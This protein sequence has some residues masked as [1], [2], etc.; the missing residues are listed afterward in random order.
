MQYYNRGILK[1][2]K[3]RPQRTRFLRKDH[4]KR[5]FQLI[6]DKKF[7]ISEFRRTVIALKSFDFS[8]LTKNQIGSKPT[9]QNDCPQIK[10]T[11]SRRNSGMS[12]N[13]RPH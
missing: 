10:P 4:N 9:N 12:I 7:P 5:P 6:I 13:H 11:I 8:C 3:P 1:I 2:K